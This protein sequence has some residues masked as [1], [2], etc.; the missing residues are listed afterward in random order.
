LLR[1]LARSTDTGGAGA[2]PGRADADCAAA[3]W[4]T[5]VVE[6]ALGGAL[7]AQSVRSTAMGV[8]KEFF[9]I[10]EV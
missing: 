9:V 8:N 4:P 10:L 7:Q 6:P 2:W 3:P 1:T 5:P